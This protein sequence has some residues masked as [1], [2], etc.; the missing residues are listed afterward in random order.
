M[1]E[2]SWLK[3]SRDA[4]QIHRRSPIDLTQIKP[5]QYDDWAAEAL[6][7]AISTVY[8]GFTPGEDPSPAYLKRARET[9]ENR[10]MYGGQRLAEIIK[11]IYGSS[12]AQTKQ[13][14]EVLF[15]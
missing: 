8:D 6:E 9:I 10:M 2:K 13:A 1:S 4:E 12:D 14:A 15:L 3:Y 7:I 5:Q 11:D